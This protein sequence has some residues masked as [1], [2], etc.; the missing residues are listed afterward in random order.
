MTR[1]HTLTDAFVELAD[2]LVSDYDVTDLL[3]NLAE[4]CVELLQAAASG[5]LLSDQRGSLHL[6]ASSTEQAR[7]VELFVLQTAE[8]PCLDAFRT[9]APVAA[10]DLAAAADRWPRFT[11]AAAAAGYAGSHAFPLRL[12]DDTI[13]ALNLFTSTAGA[14]PAADQRVAR[15]LADVA[16]IGILQER[17]IARGELLIE[18]LQGAL[19]SRI[20]I[21]QAKGIL[22]AHADI[23]MD[24]AFARL[25]H[26]S[27]S[28]NTRLTDVARSLIDGTLAAEQIPAKSAVPR[29]S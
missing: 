27:R 15:A 1:E 22:T 18:Q 2:T 28:T 20:V 25:R 19:T 21:E 26:Y 3:H 24:E 7:L 10:P 11:A 4:R 16:T 12:R 8:G 5:I 29:R 13:G 17:A 14:L 23:D 9:G 6:M